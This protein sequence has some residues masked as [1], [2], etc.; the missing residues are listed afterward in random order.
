MRVDPSSEILAAVLSGVIAWD[1]ARVLI[2]TGSAD[3]SDAGVA[4]ALFRAGFGRPTVRALGRRAVALAR[5][6]TEDTNHQ[7]GGTPS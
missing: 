7:K 6:F 5:A 3:K 1:M 2:A 4:R